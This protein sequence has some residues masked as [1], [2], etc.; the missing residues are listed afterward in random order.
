MSPGGRPAFKW[1]HQ[2]DSAE[3]LLEAALLLNCP[4]REAHRDVSRGPPCFEM[5]PSGRLLRIYPRGRPASKWPHQGDSSEHVL[6]A[7]L[8]LNGITKRRDLS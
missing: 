7:A 2:G 1:P 8:L 6:E 3:R 4:M 5:A